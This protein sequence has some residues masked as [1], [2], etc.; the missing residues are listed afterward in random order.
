MAEKSII[1][2]G[3][4]IAGLS[5]GC[6][7]QMNGYH[8]HIFE[9]HVKPGGLCTSWKRHG[10]T[11]DGCLHWLVGSGPGNS[12]HRL[13]KELGAL[14]GRRIINHDEF[15]RIEGAAGQVFIVYTDIDRLEQHMKELAPEDKEPIEELTSGMRTLARF[16]L[17]IEKAPEVWG[18]G[19]GIKTLFQ[20]LPFVGAIRKWASTSS[21]DFAARFRD[22][23]LRQAMLLLFDYFPDS[24]IAFMMMNLAWMHAKSAGY[25]IGGSWE[26][27]RSIERRYLDLGGEVSYRSPVAKV[28]VENGRAT[29]VR[30]A[31]GS[32]HRADYVISAADGHAT[33]FRML[34]GK[35]VNQKIRSYYDCLPIFPPLIHIALGVARTF[36]EVPPSISGADFPLDKPAIIAGKEY[37]RLSVHIYN[38]DSTLAPPGKTVVKVMLPSNYPY[39]KALQEHPDRYRAEKEEIADKVVAL[40]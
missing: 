6:Y 37:Q 19:D 29:G 38:F 32:E 21:R 36:E 34:E 25:P 10:Y 11:I 12:F 26:F 40:L 7:G 14:Q 15:A 3:A 39:W 18:L 28:L 20:L 35:Y 22:P 17:P 16:D 27:A 30:L 5:A 8:T 23:F 9:M 2:I 31:D 4:G 13:W 33:I 24:P 1:I